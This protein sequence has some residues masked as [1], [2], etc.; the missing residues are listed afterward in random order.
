M[1]QCEKT[2]VQICEGL[3]LKRNKNC[4]NGLSA[5]ATSKEA[6]RASQYFCIDVLYY[7]LHFI[8]IP[9]SQKYS[10]ARKALYIVLIS[11]CQ[12]LSIFHP[13]SKQYLCFV[14][15]W[16]RVSVR[17]QFDQIRLCCCP[18]VGEGAPPSPSLRLTL[19]IY[20]CLAFLVRRYECCFQFKCGG[21]SVS[22]L[23]E[24]KKV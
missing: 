15:L 12:A 13:A 9:K 20:A 1:W 10:F 19:K 5:I 6:P 14:N 18:A 4:Y 3:V 2:S 22:N 8:F 24:I 16:C 17:P 7:S 23:Q 11:C 21:F